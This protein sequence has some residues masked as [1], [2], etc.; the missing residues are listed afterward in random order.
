MPLTDTQRYSGS[1]YYE[2]VLA[3]LD[4]RDKKG[5]FPWMEAAAG[6]VK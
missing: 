4:V 1:L 3:W 2:K 6:A 5:R